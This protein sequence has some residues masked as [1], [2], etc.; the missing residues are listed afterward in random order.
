MKKTIRI[1]VI[2]ENGDSGYFIG[3]NLDKCI[4]RMMKY[5][6][7]VIGSRPKTIDITYGNIE[8]LKNTPLKPIKIFG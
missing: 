2:F 7:D 3:V 6:D 8:T 4:Q 1:D 5:G